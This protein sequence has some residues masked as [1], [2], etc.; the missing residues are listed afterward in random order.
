MN[1]ITYYLGAGASAKTMP[2]YTNFSVR[3]ENF[4]SLFKD[5]EG[6]SSLKPEDRK[7][8]REIY[9]KGMELLEGLSLH[10]TP[11]KYARVLFS[12]GNS[13]RNLKILLILF[14]V[15]QQI[16]HISYSMAENSVADRRLLDP[17]IDGL[18]S[19][20]LR[21]IQGKMELRSNFK[22]LT[23]NYDLQ[24]QIAA[25]RH[26]N[27]GIYY[28]H[29]L[30][31]GLP[32]LGEKSYEFDYK[33]F[34]IVHLN[35]LA[36]FSN[37]ICSL[38]FGH[39][40]KSEDQVVEQI[41]RYYNELKISNLP[42]KGGIGHIKFAWENLD[43]ISSLPNSKEIEVAKRIAQDTK[44]LIIFGY[45]FPHFNGEVDQFLLSNMNSLETVI[46]QDMPNKKDELLSRVGDFLEGKIDSHK[47]KYREYCEEIF[48]PFT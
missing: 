6:F 31:Q 11:D 42:G 37:D 30:L 4:L 35:G 45:S 21:P 8:A 5:G 18:F 41:I 2:V 22:I 28:S 32:I 40:L 19:R 3:F 15:E 23:W 14:F 34:G 12:N 39:L 38:R 26:C 13:T 10:S 43:P 48:Y 24:F 25:N 29:T 47:I 27:E 46:I 9:S 36:Y 7:V 17:R 33:K 16:S 1:N 20:I 44:T